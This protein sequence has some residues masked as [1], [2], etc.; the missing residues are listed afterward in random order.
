MLVP[1][2]K[3]VIVPSLQNVRL[4]KMKTIQAASRLCVACVG[5]RIKIGVRVRVRDRDRVR[6]RVR[7]RVNYY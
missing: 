1:I 2:N 3:A 5:V 7:V 4:W 6:V